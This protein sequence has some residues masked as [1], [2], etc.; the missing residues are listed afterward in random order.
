[1]LLQQKIGLTIA[2]AGLDAMRIVSEVHGAIL[3]PFKWGGFVVVAIE[4]AIFPFHSSRAPSPDFELV[5]IVRIFDIV[6]EIEGDIH[7]NDDGC[8][9]HDVVMEVLQIFDRVA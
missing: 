4:H 9:V 8:V 2:E 5:T 1:M 6:F 3:D 7:V